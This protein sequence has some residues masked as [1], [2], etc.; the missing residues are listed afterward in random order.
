M[1]LPY[2][3]VFSGLLLAVSG[4]EAQV[5]TGDRAAILTLGEILKVGIDYQLGRGLSKDLARAAELFKQACDG[6]L[7]EACERLGHMYRAGSGVTKNPSAA[8]HLDQRACDLEYITGCY[9]LLVDYEGNARASASVWAKILSLTTKS[10]NQGDF[11][12]CVGLAELYLQGPGFPKDAT[13]AAAIFQG[14]L[15]SCKAGAAPACSSLARSYIDEKWLPKDPAERA[16]ILEAAC[17]SGTPG[18]S[19]DQEVCARLRELGNA[20]S[21]GSDGLPKDGVKALRAWSRACE[22]GDAEACDSASSVDAIGTDRLKAEPPLMGSGWAGIW[23]DSKGLRDLRI[24]QATTAYVVRDRDG[25]YAARVEDGNL[26]ISKGS[27]TAVATLDPT[28]DSLTVNGSIYRR[29]TTPK[30][31]MAIAAVKNEIALIGQIRVVISA[32]AAYQSANMGW[33]AA[34]LSCLREPQGCIP[35]YPHEAPRFIEDWD[36]AS[37]VTKLGYSRLFVA[38]PNPQHANTQV[39]NV[40]RSTERWAYLATP[41]E[42]GRAFRSYCGDSKGRLCY[43]DDGSQIRLSP[44]GYCPIMTGGCLWLE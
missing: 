8:L 20:Y 32:Q 29:V 1:R 28:S 14:L 17:A 18:Y 27:R 2:R 36:L 43:R 24:T 4:L 26:V 19:L 10:C 23:W 30:E 33:F 5:A 6:G 12:D 31:L 39:V 7:A 16:T 13:R 11:D 40:S 34:T 35:N 21:V 22:G 25:A 9:G 3:I 44:D 42:T 15:M 38:G 41:N 37:G